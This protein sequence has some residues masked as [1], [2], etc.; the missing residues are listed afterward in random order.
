MNLD[1]LHIRIV[2]GHLCDRWEHSV[3]AECVFVECGGRK[4]AR[5]RREGV[6]VRG[7]G[8][9]ERAGALDLDVTVSDEAATG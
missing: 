2:L 5:K 1:I 6:C 8:T 3:E 7:K 9:N 4:Q